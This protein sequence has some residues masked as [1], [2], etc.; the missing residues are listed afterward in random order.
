MRKIQSLNFGKNDANG[1]STQEDKEFFSKLFIEDEHLNK[2]VEGSTFFLIGDKGTGKTAYAK[3]ISETDYKGNAG[4][5]V[6]MSNTDYHRFVKLKNDKK[7]AVSDYSDVWTIILLLLISEKIIETE[8]KRIF[9]FSKFKQ[10]HN[11]I[12]EFYYNAFQP[13]IQYAIQFVEQSSMGAKVI[14]DHF[15]AGVSDDKVVEFSEKRIKQNIL[16]IKRQFEDAIRSIVTNKSYIIFIDGIDVRPANIEYDEYLSCVRGLVN[17]VWQINT[18]FLSDIQKTNTTIKTCLLIRPDILDAVRPHNLNSKVRDNGLLLD[19]RTMYRDF[20]K[21]LIFKMADRLL[22]VQQEDPN[23]QLGECW[24]YYFNFKI[25]KYPGDDNP[26]NSF[27]EFLRYSF[28]R[29][30]DI[31]SLM[32]CMYVAYNEDEKK[33]AH[34]TFNKYHFLHART[35][36]SAYLLGEIRDYLSF[37]YQEQDFDLFEKFFQ[38]LSPYINKGPRSFTYDEFVEAFSAFSTYIKENDIKHPIIFNTADIFLQ[39]LYEL[40]V[41][42]FID[43]VTKYSRPLQKWCF[44][45]R[46]FNNIRPKVQSNKTYKIHFGIGKA[47]KLF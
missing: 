22:S 26:D 15:N 2:L 32:Q 11:A 19:W 18:G 37:Y 20:D 23:L 4:R 1:Y 5:L 47:L 8:D 41:I 14:F 17:A 43:G 39:F 25:E 24:N 9:N 28:Y 16:Y 34:D 36:Y 6:Q 42:C 35:E 45:E 40:N 27:I 29:P 30:R 12:D 38:L 13:E 33:S 44:R 21:S 3:Y 10:L 31:L 46:T 7:I